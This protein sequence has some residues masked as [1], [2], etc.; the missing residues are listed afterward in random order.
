[1][2]EGRHRSLSHS[3]FLFDMSYFQI[4]ELWLVFAKYR[5]GLNEV[6]EIAIMRV[7]LCFYS[8]SPIILS[9]P[10]LLGTGNA[11]AAARDIFLPDFITS[12]IVRATKTPKKMI[13]VQ[14][15]Q[16][17]F[18]ARFV[19]HKRMG[20]RMKRKLVKRLGRGWKKERCSHT[21]YCP[22]WASVPVKRSTQELQQNRL[23]TLLCPPLLLVG[24]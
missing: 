5:V 16:M 1:M 11:A 12:T 6:R 20:K 9:T 14:L 8:P 23:L 19:Q 4:F 22:R 15:V 18:W 24:R 17:L 7:P 2:I 10:Q 13:F 21:F 3:H